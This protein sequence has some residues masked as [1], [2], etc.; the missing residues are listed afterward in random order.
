LNATGVRGFGNA[1]DI[2]DQ[3]WAV[4]GASKS[5]GPAS[6]LDV[7]YAAVIYRDPAAGEPGTNPYVLWQ[8]LTPPQP[9]DL[10]LPGEFGYSVAVSA[11]E[12]WMYVGAP[13]LNQVHAYGRVTW[14]D[15]VVR[16]TSN[17]VQTVYSFAGAIQVALDTQLEVSVNSEL[18]TLGVDYQVNGLSEVEFLGDPPGLITAG[19]FVLGGIY[20]ILTVGTTDFVAIGAASNTVGVTF[21]AT[22]AGSGTGTANNGEVVDIRR[23]STK[24]ITNVT[25]SLNEYFITITI[26]DS[27]SVLVNGV[28]YRP[29]IDYTYDSGTGDLTWINA[30]GAGATG[31]YTVGTATTADEVISL[32]RARLYAIIF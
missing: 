9:A 5:V 25:T 30:P 8:L 27:F 11:D 22:G 13:G 7:G 6:E 15:Q 20:T 14:Q 16:T 17:A 2:G 24:E 12:N 31:L 28:L 21:I 18:Q 1:V 26:I 19:N 4:A 32:T 23:I 3:T 29:N 10:E